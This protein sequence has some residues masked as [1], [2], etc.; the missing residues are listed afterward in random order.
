MIVVS[1]V[2][3]QRGVSI[4]RI[5]TLEDKVVLSF[6]DLSHFDVF[7]PETVP[8]VRTVSLRKPSSSHRR[9]LSLAGIILAHVPD[10]IPALLLPIPGL[11]HCHQ[12]T[13]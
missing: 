6:Q 8:M 7:A 11:A 3:S 4:N 12:A 9:L 13:F 1:F 5:D 10:G 2:T